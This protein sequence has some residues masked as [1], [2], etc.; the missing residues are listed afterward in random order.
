MSAWITCIWVTCKSR[1]RERNREREE[2]KRKE[3]NSIFLL[4]T[5]GVRF[6]VRVNLS[7]SIIINRDD[8]E[9]RWKNWKLV[10]KFDSIRI[11]RWFERFLSG[12]EEKSLSPSTADLKKK[13]QFFIFELNREMNRKKEEKLVSWIILK[14]L[15]APPLPPPCGLIVIES[16]FSVESN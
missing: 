9:N 13:R 15:V 16:R 5:C 6:R 11:F 10:L 12:W 8:R 4:P 7:L 14:I 1:F 3:V 2:K